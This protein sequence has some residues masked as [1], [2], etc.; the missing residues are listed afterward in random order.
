MFFKIEKIDFTN[1]NSWYRMECSNVFEAQIFMNYLKTQENEY[2]NKNLLH[3]R[4]GILDMYSK[5]TPITVGF[6][7]FEVDFGEPILDD[8]IGSFDFDDYE[9]PEWTKL[10]FDVNDFLDGRHILISY[11]QKEAAMISDFL[12]EKNALIFTQEAINDNEWQIV[13]GKEE[14]ERILPVLNASYFKWGW[15]IGQSSIVYPN[16]TLSLEEILK[17]GYECEK[18]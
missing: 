14:G 17:G 15:N 7:L 5:E 8:W 13:F 2:W 11:N 4:E 10:E 3:A 1:A 6:S 16:F 9:W 12:N 18:I